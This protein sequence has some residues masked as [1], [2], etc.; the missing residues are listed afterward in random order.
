MASNAPR[1]AAASGLVL[2][3]DRAELGGDRESHLHCHRRGFVRS[4]RDAPERQ[5]QPERC[6]DSV[7]VLAAQP[8][9]A[10]LLDR[11][12]ARGASFLDVKIVE[13]PEQPRC[14][15]APFRVRGYLAKRPCGVF[16]KSKCGNALVASLEW[17]EAPPLRQQAGQNRFVCGSRAPAR[18]HALANRLKDGGRRP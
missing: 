2:D 12:P 9:V 5:G 15:A 14:P 10:L 16:R 8:A 13:S 7:D 6:Q 1:T 3:I 11:R 18:Q 17:H 4:V